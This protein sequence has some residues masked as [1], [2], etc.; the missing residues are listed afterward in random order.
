MNKMAGEKELEERQLKVLSQYRNLVL[1]LAWE[2]WRKLPASVK[3]WLD[4][5]DLIEDVYVFVLKSA[6]RK[7]DPTRG[8]QTHFLW[9]GIRNF[10]F[11]FHR[12]QIRQKRFAL[13]A[14]P[15]ESIESELQEDDN[16]IETM[17]A[18]ECLSRTYEQASTELRAEIVQW[19][20]EQSFDVHWSIDARAAY[21]EFERIARSNRLT[22]DDCL[23]LLRS[24]AWQR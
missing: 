7:F 20:T 8:S 15:I 13:Q 24:G 1:K 19:F 2:Y 18:K 16:N 3:L 4:V 5:D 9:H 22:P 21:R 6:A 17:H 23:K 14:V 10:L 12:S 11:A